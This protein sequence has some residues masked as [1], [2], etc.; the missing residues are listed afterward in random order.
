MWLR[1]RLFTPFLEEEWVFLGS[2]PW[3]PGKRK[4]TTNQ[5]SFFTPTKGGGVRPIRHFV[6]VPE[7]SWLNISTPTKPAHRGRLSAEGVF[8]WGRKL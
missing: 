1:E 5:V 8:F 6:S 4:A 3:L 7:K 2:H